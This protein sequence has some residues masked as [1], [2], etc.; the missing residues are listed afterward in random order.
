MNPFVFVAHPSRVVFGAGSLAQ[1]GREI[2]RLGARRALVLA[3]P[4]QADSARQVA[5]MLGSRAAGVFAK[6]AMHVPIAQ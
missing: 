1:L 6:A 3:T 2:E 5:E 4:E